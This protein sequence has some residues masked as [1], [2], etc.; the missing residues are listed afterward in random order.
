M[1]TEA[2]FAEA[3]AALPPMVVGGRGPQVRSRFDQHQIDALI[4]TSLTNIR[5]LTGFTGSAA[6]VVLTAGELLLVTDR[7][8][9]DQAEAQV[10]AAGAEARVAISSTEQRTLIVEAVGDAARIGLEA[11]VNADVSTLPPTLPTL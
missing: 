1:T 3:I 8:Y 7:R 10:A 9:A 2:R 11:L 4:V 5:Y 6:V